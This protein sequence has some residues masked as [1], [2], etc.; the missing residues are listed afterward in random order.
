MQAATF[1]HG[2]H[3]EAL[4]DRLIADLDAH[5]VDDPLRPHVVVVAHPALGRWL[6][7]RIAHARGIAANIEFPLPSS[8]AWDVL[9][10]VEPN[11]PRESAFSRSALTWRIHA[12]LPALVGQPAYEPVRRYLGEAADPRRR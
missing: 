12:L 6:Q 10:A 8:F 9:R 5:A 4:A 11:V 2:N 1:I 3:L 7:E